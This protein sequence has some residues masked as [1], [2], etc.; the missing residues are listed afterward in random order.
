MY[1]LRSNNNFWLHT[2]RFC[3]WNPTHWY[4]SATS[5][6]QTLL[7]SHLVSGVETFLNDH[8]N[9]KFLHQSCPLTSLGPHVLQFWGW[10]SFGR[11][12]GC[13]IPCCEQSNVQNSGM[14]FLL[15]EWKL[16]QKESSCDRKNL[17]TAVPELC[18]SKTA[19]SQV[20]MDCSSTSEWEGT[21]DQYCAKKE[22]VPSNRT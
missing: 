11:T 10:G 16:R 21:H 15:C 7:Y 2:L 1:N 22:A 19:Q 4:W 18:L 13:L 9:P 20:K 5:Q 3:L 12:W 14:Y 8:L 17:C 6:L